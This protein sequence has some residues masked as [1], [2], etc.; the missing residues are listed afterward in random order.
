[1]NRREAI[2]K[3]A[4]A[5]GYTLSAPLVSA[6]L[7]GC[8]P[9]PGITFTPVFFKEDDARMVSAIAEAILPRTTTPGAIDAGV[10]GFIDDLVGTVYSAEQQKSFTDGLA[11]FA[12]EAKSDIGDDFTGATPEQQLAFVKK[13]NS[14]ALQGNSGS[15][16][17]GWWAAGTGGSKPF[18]L[19]IKELTVLGFFTSEAGA[20]QVL[21]YK[22]V[23]GPFKGCVPLAEVG[24]A[25]AT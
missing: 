14:D 24:K 4:L 2:Q 1:M 7:N 11:A 8:T 10:P 21:Q 23:P 20:T 3:T 9:K 19:E 22:Q 12:A 16:S 25:W 18:F 6:I 17:E 5:L 13:K 15:Q